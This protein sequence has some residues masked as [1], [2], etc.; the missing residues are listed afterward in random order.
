M[1][2]FFHKL[3]LPLDKKILH[4]EIG[5]IGHRKQRYKIKQLNNNW[6]PLS[7]IDF[8]SMVMHF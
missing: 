8:Q 6:Y 1:Y 7:H 2:Y 5:L 3:A 4:L